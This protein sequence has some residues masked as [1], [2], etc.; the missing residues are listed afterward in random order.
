MEL[1]VW[2]VDVL[3]A[4]IEHR[5][6]PQGQAFRRPPLRSG[7]LKAWPCGGRILSLQEG[8]RPSLILFPQQSHFVPAPTAQNRLPNRILQNRVDSI[9]PNPSSTRIA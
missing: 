4:T 3:Q 7:L 8:G 1:D 5:S 2:R 6:P 9:E